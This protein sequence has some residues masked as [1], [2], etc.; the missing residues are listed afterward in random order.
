MKAFAKVLAVLAL[1]VL[2][3]TLASNHPYDL[4]AG[5]RPYTSRPSGC[6]AIL[7]IAPDFSSIELEDR[8]IWTFASRSI[9]TIKN[10]KADDNI[11]V[12]INSSWFG[13]QFVIQNL[14][15]DDEVGA[16]MSESPD[17]NGPY[18]NRLHNI[19]GKAITLAFNSGN[20]TGYE[21]H[22]AD[23]HFTSRLQLND[24][25]FIALNDGYCNSV[26]DYPF[27]LFDYAGDV[28]IRAKKLY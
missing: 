21:I 18:A 16:V 1:T 7:G 22:P 17:E 11:K 5:S 23:A 8:S 4:P 20:T 27:V 24:L 28:A 26:R 12:Y 2:A 15:T 13:P 14:R 19:S 6:H 25:I 9:R 10:W 3:P